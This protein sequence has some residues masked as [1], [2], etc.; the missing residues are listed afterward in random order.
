VRFTIGEGPQLDP[1][2]D[3]DAFGRLKAELDH[4]LLEPVYETI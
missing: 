1:I 3:R 2:V 4:A